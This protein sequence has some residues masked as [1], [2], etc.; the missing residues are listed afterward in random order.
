ML[1]KNI[2]LFLDSET[3][4]GHGNL[5]EKKNKLTN[6]KPVRGCINHE[7]AYEYYLIQNH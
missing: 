6:T 4:H 3:W 5:R 1:L 7:A 2:Y